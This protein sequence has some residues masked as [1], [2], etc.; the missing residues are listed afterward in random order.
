MPPANFDTA[1]YAMLLG[2][3]INVAISPFVIPFLIKLKFG[4]N[5]R[6]DGPKSHFVKSGT[7][8]MG[9]V[10]ILFSFVAASLFFLRDNRDGLMLIFVTVGF[11]LVGFLDDYIKIV[12]KRALGLRAYQKIIAQVL[13]SVIFLAYLRVE[14]SGY[15]GASFSEI[16][17]P[18][19]RGVKLDLGVLYYPFVIFVM[20]GTVNSVNLT[21]GLDGLASGVTLL[22]STFFIFMAFAAGSGSFPIVA[23]AAGSLLG[24]LLF[25][26]HPAKVFMGDTGSLALG[27][28]IAALAIMLKMSLFLPLIGVIYVIEA[29]SDIIQ[30]AYYKATK[31]R[32]FKMAP[33]HHT[34]ELSGWPETKVVTLFLI[35]TA[36]AC[37]VGFLGAKPYL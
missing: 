15:F 1:I 25:N 34:F 23:A 18:F 7:P 11:G 31:K 33:I 17:M 22:V 16:V 35:V 19:V 27:G 6:D 30:V 13:V 21:D 10:M 20:I 37:L 4:Q 26:A 3:F 32:V 28:L 14:D 8:T 9:G 29:I 24:F 5:V 12:K 2:F 36:I